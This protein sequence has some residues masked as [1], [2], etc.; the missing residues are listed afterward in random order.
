[1]CKQQT[2]VSS[3][4]KLMLMVTFVVMYNKFFFEK[5]CVRDLKVMIIYHGYMN[6]S[7]YE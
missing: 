1:M 4:K 6:M 3:K 7:T 2:V 5:W